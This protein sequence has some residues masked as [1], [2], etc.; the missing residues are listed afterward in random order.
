MPHAWASCRTGAG[1]ASTHIR[2]R[3]RLQGR[4]WS[5]PGTTP[6]RREWER[7]PFTRGTRA[8]PGKSRSRWTPLASPNRPAKRQIHATARIALRR[9]RT[10]SPRS[11]Q[12][13]PTRRLGGCDR[14][15]PCRA[16]PQ[17]K[18]EWSQRTARVWLVRSDRATGRRHI[19]PDATAV[20]QCE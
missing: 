20:R 8:V 9:R 3:S 17:Q 6:F 16:P 12:M 15:L 4:L 7:I 10:A 5:H 2:L 18:E 19:Q 13:G 1:H 11:R 14:V